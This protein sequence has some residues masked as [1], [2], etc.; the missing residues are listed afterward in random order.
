M[1]EVYVAITSAVRVPFCGQWEQNLGK[2]GKKPGIKY[3]GF[4]IVNSGWGW[5][6]KQAEAQTS[7]RVSDTYSFP[8]MSEK[9]LSWKIIHFPS[10]VRNILHR[11]ESL[12]CIIV[13]GLSM[14]AV[15]PSV[16]E[17]WPL[18]LTPERGQKEALNFSDSP[19]SC[20]NSSPE[21]SV[22][23]QEDLL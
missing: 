19:W 12:A 3:L 10:V 2:K 11:S 1:L 4:W 23:W 9:S 17:L 16:A 15:G 18:L 8:Q 5:S 7:Q 6:A 13:A 20:S 21:P 14:A 22:P